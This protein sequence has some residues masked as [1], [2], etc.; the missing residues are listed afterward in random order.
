MPEMLITAALLICVHAFIYWAFAKLLYGVSKRKHPNYNRELSHQEVNALSRLSAEL[1]SDSRSFRYPWYYRLILFG[2]TPVA[3]GVGLIVGGLFVILPIAQKVLEKSIAEPPVWSDITVV[4]LVSMLFGGFAGIF[5]SA[6]IAIVIARKHSLFLK[7]LSYQIGWGTLHGGE[8]SSETVHNELIDAYRK[9]RVAL[10][11][12]AND[13]E[14]IHKILFER[15]TP[16]WIAGTAF[17]LT[18][19]LLFSV[20]DFRNFAYITPDKVVAS[21]YF[22][23]RSKTYD[24]S[25][26]FKLDRHCYI[27]LADR[28]PVSTL[29]Y[30]LILPDGKSIDLTK[31][32]DSI[33]AVDN[34]LR[35]WS[36]VSRPPVRVEVFKRVKGVNNNLETCKGLLKPKTYE[37][38]PRSFLELYEL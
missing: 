8:K 33:V 11:I 7:Y 22:S 23:V 21:P 16:F 31:D 19:T 28:S 24:K 30:A 10:D 15:T 13:R 1:Y 9:N 36:G 18:L 17:L 3:L 12:A 25:E 26:D 35:N 37:K 2:L 34:R 29:Q 4:P 5:L 14:S 38:L 6:I 32:M 20:F 27:H